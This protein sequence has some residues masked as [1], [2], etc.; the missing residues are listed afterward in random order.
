VI[1]I[2]PFLRAIVVCAWSCA[3]VVC[4]GCCPRVS[5]VDV[6]PLSAQRALVSMAVAHRGNLHRGALPDNSAPALLE[7]MNAG[8]P[9]LEVDVRRSREGELFLF[10]DGS[11]QSGNSYAPRD[12]VGR[13]AQ[14][15]SRRE[16]ERVF[17]DRGRA[18]P[19]PTLEDALRLVQA[20]QG[21]SLQLDFKGES[22]ELV[23]AALDLVVQRDML[24]RVVV[25]LRSV[26]RVQAVKQHYPGVRISARCRD[27]VQLKT[28]LERGV[29][30]VELERWVSS[31]AIRAA[32]ATN[33]RVLLNI[34]GTRLDEPSTWRY[35]R[36]RGVDVIMSDYADRH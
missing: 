18:I 9:L 1:R 15:L 16:R 10:H 19:I 26:E 34:A 14:G 3:F 27:S 20:S 24:S 21:S 11:I 29:E 7:A 22:D 12:L 36:S 2:Q 30:M 13:P 25:Q 32:H 33:T 5:M 8:V 4:S 6:G 17:L 35:L 23:F 31:E 28:A